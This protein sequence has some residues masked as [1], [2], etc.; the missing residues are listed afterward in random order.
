VKKKSKKSSSYSQVKWTSD[1]WVEE[2]D[3]EQRLLSSI[4]NQTE[5]AP[6]TRRFSL[7]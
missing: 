4:T 7:L 2:G 3:V 1:L 5:L 6:P